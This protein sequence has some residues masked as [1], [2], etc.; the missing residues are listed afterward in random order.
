MDGYSISELMAAWNI[1]LL[2]ER[3][4]KAKG[5]REALFIFLTARGLAISERDRAR[6]EA[7]TNS[8]KLD[9]WIKRAA[10][11]R[12]VRALLEVAPAK[13]KR[14]PVPKAKVVASGRGSRKRA[15]GS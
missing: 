1:R 10:T 13:V 8:E 6:I 9:R 7:C 3:G 11:A 14:R 4:G 12:S 2:L 15:A 5:K